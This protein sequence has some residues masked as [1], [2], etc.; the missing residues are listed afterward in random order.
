MDRMYKA[1]LDDCHPNK[2]ID[3]C[4][5]LR[6]SSVDITYHSCKLKATLLVGIHRKMLNRPKEMNADST[7]RLTR[8]HVLRLYRRHSFPLACLIFSLMILVAFACMF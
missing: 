4:H 8:H 7:N 5:Y 6:L 2:N 1:N 3:L